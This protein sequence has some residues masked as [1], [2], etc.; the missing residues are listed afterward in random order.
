MHIK[1]VLGV[2]YCAMNKRSKG[3]LKVLNV[4]FAAFMQH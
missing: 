3:M 1:G 4:V 2:K